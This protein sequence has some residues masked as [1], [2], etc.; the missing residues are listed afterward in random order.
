PGGGRQ[1]AQRDCLPEK[2][3]TYTQGMEMEK[4]KALLDGMLFE[5]FFDPE[6]QLR[7]K[8]KGLWLSE[9][10][11]L[12]QYAELSESFEFIAECLI[13]HA[14]GKVFRITKTPVAVF[15][16][17]ISTATVWPLPGIAWKRLE[18]AA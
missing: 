15:L 8:P 2:V 16:V 18:G 4:R 5:I 3:M 13:Q 17:T 6:A 9:V 1:R 12:Q 11:E 7:A 14:D 10:F